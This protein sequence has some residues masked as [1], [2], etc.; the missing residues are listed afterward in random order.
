V[1][2]NCRYHEKNRKLNLNINTELSPNSLLTI[3]SKVVDSRKRVTIQIGPK[4]EKI[5]LNFFSLIISSSYLAATISRIASSDYVLSHDNKLTVQWR[6]T[7]D[8]NFLACSIQNLTLNLIEISKK[9]KVS[10]ESRKANTLDFGLTFNTILSP[11]KSYE[12]EINGAEFE[13]QEDEEPK[14]VETMKMKVERVTHSSFRVMLDKTQLCDGKF[15]VEVENSEGKIIKTFSREEEEVSGLQSCQR[16]TI[17]LYQTSETGK[18]T[19]LS[20]V[21]YQLDP[22]DDELRKLTVENINVISYSNVMLSSWTLPNF[23]ENCVKIYQL[24][25]QSDVESRN[26]TTERTEIIFRE[27]F[28]CANYTLEVI[29]VFVNGSEL[30]KAATKAFCVPPRGKIF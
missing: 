27:V 3:T 1:T 20:R 28:A 18:R 9:G 30:P 10:V 8:S 6:L 19:L 2:L 5:I 21:N 15:Q 16:Y 29:I 22:S 7:L 26:T 24:K 4:S 17:K 11:C 25:L 13:N 12:Y 14:T 23:F